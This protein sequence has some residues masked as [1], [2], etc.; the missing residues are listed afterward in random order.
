MTADPAH[1]GPLSAQ[2]V[3][4]AGSD[5]GQTAVDDGSD[6]DSGHASGDDSAS[7]DPEDVYAD[8]LAVRKELEVRSAATPTD[9]P[10]PYSLDSVPQAFYAEWAPRCPIQQRELPEKYTP[11]PTNP[12]PPLLHFVLPVSPR[13]LLE[14]AKRKGTIAYSQWSPDDPAPATIPQTV[15]A[16]ND[17]CG[18]AHLHTVAYRIGYDDFRNNYGI[19]LALYDNY[20]VDAFRRSEAAE[21][22]LVARINAALDVHDG[23]PPMW[24]F[25][26][27]DPWHPGLPP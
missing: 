27:N 21:A 7:D 16:L 17:D 11:S 3:D 24:Y 22:R 4:D 14:Y 20:N 25:D 6:N 26:Y 2:I 9:A 19:A 13:S 10:R 12:K 18:V 5:A 23:P 1:S 8:Q 15:R